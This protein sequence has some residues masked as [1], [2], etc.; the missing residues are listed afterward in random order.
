MNSRPIAD[1]DPAALDV[2][3]E[4]MDLWYADAI[5]APL[6]QWYHRIPMN[7]TYWTNY[8]SAENPYIQPAF[9]YIT[10][11]AGYLFLN[12]ERAGD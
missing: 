1:G 6:S 11:Q 2:F 5:E 8:P 10:G 4:A 12:L 7:Q 3:A 9:W